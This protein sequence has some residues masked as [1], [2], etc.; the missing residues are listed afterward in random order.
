IYRGAIA[1]IL[2]IIGACLKRYS[3]FPESW[4][5]QIARLIFNGLASYLLV[6]SFTYLSASTVSLISRIDVP[7]LIFLS[8]YLGKEKSDLQFWL[9]VWCVLVI[10]FL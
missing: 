2:G 7:F 8:V 10:L 9:S 1:L 3:L 5:P 4:K 6:S